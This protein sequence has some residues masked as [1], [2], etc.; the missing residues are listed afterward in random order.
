MVVRTMVATGDRRLILC[1]DIF[2][3]CYNASDTDAVAIASAHANAHAAAAAIAVA[4]A[5]AAAYAAANA[6][7]LWKGNFHEDRQYRCLFSARLYCRSVLA[8]TRETY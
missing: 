2:N 6:T 8:G 1:R 7:V 5:N 3:L 4:F